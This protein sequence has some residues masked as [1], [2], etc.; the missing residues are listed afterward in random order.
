MIIIS[1]QRGSGISTETISEAAPL[2]G[3]TFLHGVTIAAMENILAIGPVVA[4]SIGMAIAA[5]HQSLRLSYQQGYLLPL[6]DNK[7]QDIICPDG[8]TY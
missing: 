5:N 1:Y 2:S 4:A 8:H 3:M 7:H 6:E